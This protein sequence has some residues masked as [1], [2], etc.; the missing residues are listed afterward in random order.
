VYPYHYDQ[1]WVTRINRGQERGAA[2]TRGLQE[3]KDAL[4][5][6]GIEMRL[7]DWYPR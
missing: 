2:T 5:A 7:A 6:A 1:D 3:L 4:A